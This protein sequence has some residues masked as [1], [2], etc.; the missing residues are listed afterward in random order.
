MEETTVATLPETIGSVLATM[1]RLTIVNDADMQVA[2]EWLKRCKET[3]RF[4]KEHYE[5]QRLTTYA[6]YQSVTKAIKDT[7]TPLEKAETTV[8]GMLS[9]YQREQER[10]AEQERRR[11]ADEAL[12]KARRETEDRMLAEAA[13]KNDETILDKPVVVAPLPPPPPPPKPASVQGVSYVTRWEY[14]IIDQD[15][16]PREYMIPDLANIAK[17]V[18]T[19]KDKTAIPGVEAYSTKTVRVA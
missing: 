2:A 6:A 17:V 5:E 10:K 1:Q 7:L 14:R 13:A 4:V 19:M 11:I 9:T 15:L 12:A 8:K 3:Q 16:I 18:Q